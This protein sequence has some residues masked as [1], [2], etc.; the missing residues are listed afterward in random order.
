MYF[1]WNSKPYLKSV[2]PENI[3]VQEL[4]SFNSVGNIVFKHLEKTAQII[5]HAIALYLNLEASYFDKFIQEGNSILR[6]IHY[7]P[8]TKPPHEAERAA[9]HGDINLMN[10]E[11]NQ[12]LKINFKYNHFLIF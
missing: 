8:I 12:L 6:A 5:L 9:A 4:T 1:Y 11:H 7:P 10:Q 2:Y 3:I